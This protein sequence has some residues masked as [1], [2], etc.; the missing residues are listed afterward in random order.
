MVLLLH[1]FCNNHYFRLTVFVSAEVV[2]RLRI[3]HVHRPLS[4]AIQQLDML[5]KQFWLLIC[6]SLH[7]DFLFY[8]LLLLT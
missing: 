2:V 6:S 5:Q 3:V 4:R 7:S 1:V 8:F